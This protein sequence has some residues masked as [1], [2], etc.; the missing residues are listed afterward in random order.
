MNNIPKTA[1]ANN[2]GNTQR[3]ADSNPVAGRSVARAPGSGE[4]RP[5]AAAASAIGAQ[6]AQQ[7]VRFSTSTNG[8]VQEQI[9]MFKS[10]EPMTPQNAAI[11]DKQGTLIIILKQLLATNS[12]IPPVL[13]TTTPDA[14]R[15]ESN[16]TPAQPQ[17]SADTA[18]AQ[19][20]RSA[21]AAPS[22][23]RRSTD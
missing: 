3:T 14:S 5:T 2:G 12:P 22:L 15:W 19:P 1:P 7:G 21:D 18:P 6:A 10:H 8:R 4:Q 9:R 16:S 13:E 17:R 11:G 23:P 20:Q